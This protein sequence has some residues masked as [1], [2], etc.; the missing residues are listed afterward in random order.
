VVLDA[1]RGFKQLR[2][3]GGNVKL[4]GGG[5]FTIQSLQLVGCSLESEKSLK[6]DIL[7]LESD[8]SFSSQS[9]LTALVTI[10]G[11]SDTPAFSAMRGKHRLGEIQSQVPVD[12]E[13]EPWI[14]SL[15]LGPGEFA[16]DKVDSAINLLTLHGASFHLDHPM[17]A[18]SELTIAGYGKVHLGNRT[19]CHRIRFEP[20]SQNGI[21]PLEVS[22]SPEAR[23]TEASGVIRLGQLGVQ[24]LSR[25][26]SMTRYR[27]SQS[28][29]SLVRN[30]T[31]SIWQVFH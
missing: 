20:Q 24:R 8:S 18:V 2:L 23:L 3:E 10:V 7:V 1:G 29:R 16:V 9:S 12:S 11:G 30:S 17:R 6:V 31:M 26:R 15:T 21:L 19:R 14:R 28:R 22:L 4:E 27:S 25:D 5:A 13:T